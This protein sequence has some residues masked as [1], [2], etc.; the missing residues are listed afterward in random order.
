M[1]DAGIRE[2]AQ[3]GGPR[4]SG[5]VRRLGAGRRRLV[6]RDPGLL[7][8]LDRLVDP[9][10]RGDPESPLRWTCKSTRQLARALTQAGHPVSAD[11]VGRLLRA[12]GYA[13]QR[14]AKTLEGR[15][16]PDRDAQFHISQ[17]AAAQLA[18]GQPVVSVDAKKKELVGVFAN[19]GA[20][21][22]PSG[23]PERVRVHDFPDPALSKAI[24][25]GIDDLGANTGWVSVG[26]DHETSA[27]AVATLRRWWDGVG[28]LPTRT[29]TGCWSAPMLA[30]VMPI[31]GGCGRPSW[32]GWRPRP[33][34]RSWCAIFRLEAVDIA[35][36]KVQ[37]SGG[38]TLSRRMCALAEDSGVQLMGSGLTDS[39]VGFGASLHLFA[40]YGVDRPVDLNGRQFIESPYAG[41]TVRVEAG[42]AH[43]PD[44]PGLG[45][46]VN[47]AA[48]REL[49]VN[50][51]ETR[52]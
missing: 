32:A 52:T 9:D 47:E 41:P 20:K 10:T 30:A 49:A 1:V 2:L 26:C 33:A 13:L 15:Q 17:Q 36:A 16:H 5:R 45:V 27:F 37:R 31:G 23:Q 34:C 7:E 48:V 18:D 29:P 28:R 35:I 44:S 38:L 22:Q 40:A 8:A 42:T 43:V 51:L 4:D 19:G 14:T 46:E 12:Q 50:V 6:E 24:P 3:P 11:T 39:D 25:Y 21:W